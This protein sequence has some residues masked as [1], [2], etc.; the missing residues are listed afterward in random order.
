MNTLALWEHALTHLRATEPDPDGQLHQ[1]RADLPQNRTDQDLLSEYGWVVACCGLTPHVMMKHWDRLSSAFHAWDPQAVAARPVDVRTA[2]L[3]VIKNPRKM[4]VII[5]FA[6]DL[7][8]EPGMM[9]RL[10]PRPVKEV[11]TW[12]STLP[13]VGATNRYHLA[14]NLG[15]DVVVRSGPVP[16]LAAYLLTTPEELCARI[17]AETGERIRTVDLVLWNWGYQVGDP[18]M[19]EMASL[20]RLL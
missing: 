20:F 1:W 18:A 2:A 13:Y 16:R 6:Q 14:R 11:L 15:W 9:Q 4:D 12:F 8:R 5:A 7:A 3:E 10:A 19:K 17:A